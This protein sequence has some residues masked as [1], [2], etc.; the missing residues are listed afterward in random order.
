MRAIGVSHTA[1]KYE[2]RRNRRSHSWSVGY[3]FIIMRHA[4]LRGHIT[5]QLQQWMGGTDL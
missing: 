3:F 2:F 4:L 5:G 1:C